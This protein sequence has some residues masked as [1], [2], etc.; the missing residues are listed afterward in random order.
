MLDTLII[1]AGFWGTAIALELQKHNQNFQLLDSG[2][3]E[4]ASPVAAGL[5]RQSGLDQL[6]APWWTPQHLQACHEFLRHW[7]RSELEW[8]GNPSQPLGRLRPGLWLLDPTVL[9]QHFQPIRL[10]V[11][12]LRTTSL[13]WTIECQG[14]NLQARQ[15]VLA[16]GIHCDTILKASELPPIGLQALPGEALLGAA[17]HPLDY[18]RTWSYRLPGDSRTRTVTARNWPEQGLRVGDT[19]GDKAGQWDMLLH[20]FQ[21]MGGQGPTQRLWGIRPKAAQGLVVE[22]WAPG[23]VVASGGQRNGLASAAGVAL[24]VHQLLTS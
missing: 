1:G 14:Q 7:G 11:H 12:R 15:I 22:R 8:I 5:V 6:T 10:R 21:E 16:A 9:L 13:H 17:S 24:R 3:A 2:E 18:P 19:L 4:A 23:L 20:W